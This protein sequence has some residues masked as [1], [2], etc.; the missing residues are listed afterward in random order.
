MRLTRL[1]LSFVFA[2]AVALVACGGDDGG[3]TPADTM[4]DTP[5]AVMGI[6]KR[7]GMGGGQ[8]DA[9]APICLSLMQGGPGFCSA[10]CLDNG[11]GTTN[12]MAAF[13]QGSLTPAPNPQL[14]TAAFSAPAGMAVCG[15]VIETVPAHNPLMANTAYTGVDIACLIACGAGNAC[16]TGLTCDTARGNLCLP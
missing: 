12:A 13:P 5:M 1:S 16:P 2:A 8:C 14:C 15:T 4:P 11:A 10:L 9:N 7:C 3:S 6:G